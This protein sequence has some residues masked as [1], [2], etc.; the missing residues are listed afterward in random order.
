VT[1]VGVTVMALLAD[2]AYD[3]QWVATTGVEGNGGGEPHFAL[4][5]R[6]LG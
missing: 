5:L 2:L 3:G 1:G 6:P 4:G